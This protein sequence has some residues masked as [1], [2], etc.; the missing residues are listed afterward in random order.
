MLNKTNSQIMHLHTRQSDSSQWC[1][2]IARGLA[3]RRAICEQCAALDRAHRAEGSRPVARP[4][5]S[6]PSRSDR[7]A[8]LFSRGAESSIRVLE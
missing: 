1:R 4:E 3:A 2:G 8:P 7:R 6:R 5:R